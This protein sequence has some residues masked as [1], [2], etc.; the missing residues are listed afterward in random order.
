MVVFSQHYIL[1]NFFL[2]KTY[3]YFFFLFFLSLFLFKQNRERG[4]VRRGLA[5]DT[6]KFTTLDDSGLLSVSRS[7][8]LKH[9]MIPCQFAP[10]FREAA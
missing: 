4:G 3:A 2:V 7:L 10:R 6:G 9:K 8:L 1:N 5:V